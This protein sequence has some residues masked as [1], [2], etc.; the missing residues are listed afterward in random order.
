MTITEHERRMVRVNARRN[1]HMQFLE[2]NSDAIERIGEHGPDG[3][4]IDTLLCRTLA[5][6]AAWETYCRIYE[7][8]LVDTTEAG[9]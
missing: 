8:N 6:A 9:R 3:S 1:T 5:T 7:R 4:E 2:D